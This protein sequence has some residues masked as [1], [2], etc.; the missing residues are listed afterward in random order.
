M[1][2]KTLKPSIARRSGFPDSGENYRYNT[3]RRSTLVL[4]GDNGKGVQ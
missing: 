1:K 4:L 2:R 3:I